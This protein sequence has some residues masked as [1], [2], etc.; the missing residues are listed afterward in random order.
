MPEIL[1]SPLRMNCL[2]IDLVS[3]VDRMEP[4]YFP[5]LFN[6]R[7]VEEGCIEARPG[8]TAAN[9]PLVLTS[10]NSI[11]R[12][13]DTA[14]IY[15]A[16]GYTYI[17]GN[18]AELW[19]GPVASLAS[20]D[21]GYSG[22]PL[23]LIT[24]R[25]ENSPSSWMYVYDENKLVKVRPDGLVRSI[26][27]VPPNAAPVAT[28]GRPAMVTLSDGDVITGWTASGTSS[29][30][31]DTDR[32]TNTGL[33]IGSILYDTGSTG[34]ACIVPIASTGGFGWTGDR[35]RIVLD[36][37]GGNEELC[38]VREVHPAVAS[39]T[40]AAI[41]YDSGST[42]LCSIVLTDYVANIE[43]NTVL[44][45]DFGGGNDEFVRVLEVV[46]SPDG[47]TY[48]LRCS[49]TLTHV[50]TETADGAICF[51]TY[52]VATHVATEVIEI[53]YVNVTQTT[54]AGAI[55]KTGAIDASMALGR[56]V[57]MAD[58]YMHI[59]FFTTS[60]ALLTSLT[61][62]ID[63]DAA[64][65]T[66]FTANYLTF[67]VD[68]T[69]LGLGWNEIVIPLSEGVRTGTDH[70]SN[71]KTVQALQIQIVT[72]G[73]M[74]YGFDCWYL[75][76][77]YGPTIQPNSPT[78][79]LYAS[80]Y[81]DS[82]TGVATTPSPSTRYEL[83]PLRE[84]VLVVPAQST[85]SGADALDIYRQ[86]GALSQFTYVG[87]VNNGETFSDEYADDT[88]AANPV[89]DLTL[90]QPWSTLQ[91]GLSGTVDVVGTSVTKATGDDFPTKLAAGSII[92][93]NGIAYQTYG[94]PSSS[95]RLELNRS[96]GDQTGVAYQ[97]QSPILFGQ[98]LPFA[99]GPLEGP[100]SP[101]VFA[102]GDPLNPG[103][104]YFTNS[105]NSD[106]AP[107]TN[108]LEICAPSEPLIS[109]DCWYTMAIVGSRDNI[110]RVRYSFLSQAS[111]ST[112]TTYQSEKIPSASGMW[113][114]WACKRGPDGVYFL[115]RDG[116]YLANEAQAVCISNDKLYPLFPHDGQVAS[117]VD[118]GGGSVYLPVDMTRLESL[119]FSVCDWD[120]YFDYID[121]GS[122]QVTLRYDIKVKRWFPHS[123]ADA[124]VTHYLVEPLATDPNQMQILMLGLLR[125]L[126]YLAGGNTDN[127]Q[128][129]NSI[130]LTPSTDGGDERAQ[131]LYVD[132]M[133]DADGT[134]NLTV[135]AF[136]NNNTANSGVTTMALAGTRLQAQQNI[137]SQG[138]L[139]LYR[140]IAAKFAWTGGP[141]G[142][143]IY[144]Y[145]PSGYLQPYLS[146][147]IVTQY[148]DMSFFGWKHFRRYYPALISTTPVT[149]TIKT[150]DGRTYGPY[151]IAS[152]AGQFR[153]LPAIIDHGCKDLAFSF[154]I[155]AEEVFAL[156]PKEFVVEAK[157]WTQPEYA[158]VA[159]FLS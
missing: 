59:S 146:K 1:R 89:I 141:S 105:A 149:F 115:G 119:R 72:T 108:T 84:R 10:L 142:P 74:N 68:I 90:V 87:T 66:A 157:Q 8:Y 128:A 139:A 78:G 138:D 69:Q 130:V 55:T 54:G 86:G 30:P 92:L 20:I 151:T 23:S 144:A 102:L 152:T 153:L 40:I 150:Q 5:Y 76:G 60:T 37:G 95:S 147:R 12:L 52:T 62:R 131:K 88:I 4:G 98:P 48:S 133:V 83:F 42:G 3:P 156:F 91:I 39:T 135:A 109:G 132:A 41:K 63:I 143:R 58:D 117:S 94:S 104:L 80:R 18:G 123:Y 61:L 116:I 43:R 36:P 35:M 29:A 82:T 75:F 154:Q 56:P 70:L 93:I 118:F 13:N 96:A 47:V 65:G 103:T 26:G 122:N 145:E 21:T 155:E 31:T 81:R 129:I 136:Y 67:A 19:Q 16:L 114:R 126:V 7:V 33:T 100:F 17:V 28:Y 127:G 85:Q 6:T 112:N 50:A 46:P 27:F 53:D 140:N 73:S 2:G 57:S 99:F 106:A 49:T 14:A 32:E 134:G 148:I 64:A 137:A 22:K 34:W 107:D 97:I 38:L 15:N 9:T 101:V 79:Y 71:L 24:F 125:G 124:M 45:L 121:T 158:H 120:L 159:V 11:R 110:Y 51:Y 77:T 111:A 44:L 25:P 113:S